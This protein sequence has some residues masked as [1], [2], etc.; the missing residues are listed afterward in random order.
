MYIYNRQGI[1][2]YST[3]DPTIGWT[4]SATT[5]QGVYTYAIRCRYNTND[6]KTYAG[7]VTLIK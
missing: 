7:T 1:L 3:T 4:P 6:I 2:V 5:S